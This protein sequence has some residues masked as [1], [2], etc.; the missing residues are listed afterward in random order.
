MHSPWRGELSIWRG[1]E[2]IWIGTVWWDWVDRAETW[3]AHNKKQHV[4]FFF[5]IFTICNVLPSTRKATSTSSYRKS[6]D[7]ECSE[8]SLERGQIQGGPL[9]RSD[10]P[11]FPIFLLFLFAEEKRFNFHS[12]AFSA[13]KKLLLWMT[14]LKVVISSVCAKSWPLHVKEGKRLIGVQRSCPK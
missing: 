12:G 7:L 8:D 4:Y 3:N 1:D 14:V 6:V 10:W 11:Q 9:F 5:I 13:R 2:R